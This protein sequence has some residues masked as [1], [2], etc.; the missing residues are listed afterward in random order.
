M[1]ICQSILI[2]WNQTCFSQAYIIS[3]YITLLTHNSFS[4]KMQVSHIHSKKNLV[5]KAIKKVKESNSEQRITNWNKI[6]EKLKVKFWFVFFFR[7]W[8]S[9]F[10]P[11]RKSKQIFQFL[12]PN[13]IQIFKK[14]T[15]DG[16]AWPRHQK[17]TW[18]SGSDFLNL[19]Y[20][21]AVD[22]L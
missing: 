10:K 21:S 15:E 18:I 20:H 2:R 16:L 17:I 19:S 8:K 12:F 1:Q 9:M 6:R 5:R 4:K 7:L 3:I 22:I 14:M 13:Y 11:G